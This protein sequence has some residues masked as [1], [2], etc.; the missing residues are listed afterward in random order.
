MATV[1]AAAVVAEAGDAGKRSKFM[2]AD[3]SRDRGRVPV[4][5]AGTAACKIILEVVHW[6]AI[7]PEEVVAQSSID[8]SRCRHVN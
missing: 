5:A 7:S 1:V 3:R 2:R 8:A 6:V 4:L